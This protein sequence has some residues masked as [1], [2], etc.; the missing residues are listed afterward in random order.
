MLVRPL[1]RSASGGAR[2]LARPF[3]SSTKIASAAIS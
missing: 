2:R 3:L 1:L